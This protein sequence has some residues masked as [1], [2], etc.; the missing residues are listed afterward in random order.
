MLIQS[1]CGNIK[2]DCD[3]IPNPKTV[4]GEA[5][6]REKLDGVELRTLRE[7]RLSQ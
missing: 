3:S 6:H 5:L 2:K 1:P 7:V 4:P